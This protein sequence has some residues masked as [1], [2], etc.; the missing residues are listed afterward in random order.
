V[1]PAQKH[2]GAFGRQQAFFDE[3]C[4][5]TRAEQ[6]FERTGAGFGQKFTMK[7]LSSMTSWG[8]CPNRLK[9]DF[10]SV[11]VRFVS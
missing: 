11:I 6:L 5:G 7:S 8:E 9:S 4:D 2:P 1:L 10:L 3:E